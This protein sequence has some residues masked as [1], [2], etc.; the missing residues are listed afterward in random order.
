LWWRGFRER[1]ERLVR[2]TEAQSLETIERRLAHL[3]SMIEGLQDA[4]HRESV[5]QQIEIEQ[6]ER[7]VDPAALRRALGRDAR[8]HGL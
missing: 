7:R 1:R 2:P 8:E 4:M 5:R 6:L 3:E